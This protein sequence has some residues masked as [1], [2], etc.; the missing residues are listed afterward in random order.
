MRSMLAAAL[1]VAACAFA[2][3]VSATEPAPFDRFGAAAPD[4]VVPV[5][6]SVFVP[7]GQEGVDEE[8]A[9]SIRE[10]FTTSASNEAS[11]NRTWGRYDVGFEL[12]SL[13]P[14]PQSAGLEV[15]LLAGDEGASACD[16]T[17][18]YRSFVDLDDNAVDIVVGGE[19]REPVGVRVLAA[20][21]CGPF[22]FCEPSGSS[23]D[24]ILAHHAVFKHRP[25]VIAHE[26]GH[27]L[28]L[29]HAGFPSPCGNDLVEDA[30]EPEVRNLMAA[31]VGDGD[32]LTAGQQ[33]RA[34][35][36]LCSYDGW[37]REQGRCAADLDGT[38]DDAAALG[39]Y[40][41]GT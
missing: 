39:R 11:V 36:V 34:W 4:A 1:A 26:L 23:A 22:E 25:E 24:V 27:L 18:R 30:E 40:E 32:D 29:A 33:L 35:T 41:R 20:G 12:M 19:I 31:D 38:G 9:A 28:G 2:G 5:H 13:R 21:T 16:A 8:L 6:V 10:V 7:D 37:V 15:E 3:C 14:I 17:A